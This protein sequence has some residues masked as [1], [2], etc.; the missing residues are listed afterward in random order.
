M[1]GGIATNADGQVITGELKDGTVKVFDIGGS[2]HLSFNLLF[3]INLLIYYV[4]TDMNEN[5]YVLVRPRKL[6]AGKVYYEVCSVENGFEVHVYT[7]T[8]DL[9]HK[10]PLIRSGLCL[11]LAVG[12]SKVFVLNRTEN[13]KY[14][15]DVSDYADGRYVRSIEEDELRCAVDIAATSDGHVMLLNLGKRVFVFTENDQKQRKFSTD[16]QELSY[17][18]LIS[19]DPTSEHVVVAGR[20]LF[21]ETKWCLFALIYT[22]DGKF[23]RSITIDQSVEGPEDMGLRGVAVSKHGHIVLAIKDEYGKGKVIVL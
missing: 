13:F 16:T 3:F 10:F 20:T 7:K 5:I 17:C 15:I 21:A 2:F 23:E 22:K 1:A 4:A 18:C 11:K 14:A 6:V 19:C 12:N 9:L 8:A